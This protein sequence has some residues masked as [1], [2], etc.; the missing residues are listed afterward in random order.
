MTK[1]IPL[2]MV[3]FPAA[4]PTSNAEEGFQNA[5]VA[6]AFAL[7]VEPA[8]AVP[9]FDAPCSKTWKPAPKVA[10]A[11]NSAHKA[12]VCF[13]IIIAMIVIKCSYNKR[14]TAANYSMSAFF[15]KPKMRP[16]VIFCQIDTIIYYL[17]KNYSER[18]HQNQ[19]PTD[20]DL[21]RRMFEIFRI[22]ETSQTANATAQ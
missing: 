12:V 9:R 16:Q 21:R 11:P 19:K 4:S 2:S 5:D 22:C 13:I 8:S 14:N 7:A 3:V 18:T 15:G 10:H 1:F 17:S 6:S 20:Y